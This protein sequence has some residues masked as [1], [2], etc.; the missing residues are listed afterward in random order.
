VGGYERKEFSAEIRA[1]TDGGTG[2]GEFEGIASAFFSIDDSWW[3]DIVAPGAFAA[4]LPLFLAE[5]FVG[6]LN[7]DWDRP[8]GRP[9]EARE[10]TA[11]LFVRARLSDTPAA[12][13]VRT[14]IRDGV[15]GRLSI[16]FRILGKE[17][18]ETAE[19]VE[20]WWAG[21]GYPPTDED[22]AKSRHGARVLTRV[23]LYEF[24]PVAVPANRGAVITGWKIGRP[25]GTEGTGW[26]LP[27]PYDPMERL[28]IGRSLAA[29]SAGVLAALGEWAD[30]LE[31][32]SALREV[33]RRA[34]SR[35]H[36][37]G[38][39]RIRSLI[40]RVMEGPAGARP[41]APREGEAEPEGPPSAAAF[42]EVCETMAALERRLGA[43]GVTG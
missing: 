10:T 27:D 6:G 16:G 9:A 22:R 23:R 26:D 38:L 11:G 24:S 41:A 15:I 14:L 2:A 13:E 43:L 18:L 33:S 31:A 3:N 30:R 17:H 1:G 29:H 39:R 21:H 42:R 35:D 34:L 19:E 4:D 32:A 25:E 5:G 8:I 37:A 20:S 12:R 40:E 28:R 36:R 7:H